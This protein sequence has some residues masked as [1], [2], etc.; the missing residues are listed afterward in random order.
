M[1][2]ANS[3]TKWEDVVI[4]HSKLNDLKTKMILLGFNETIQSNLAKTVLYYQREVLL[5][6]L[7]KHGAELATA[8]GL[9]RLM[10]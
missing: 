5:L 9:C 6:Q 2:E 10:L 8:T 7:V 1:V 4:I 3:Y